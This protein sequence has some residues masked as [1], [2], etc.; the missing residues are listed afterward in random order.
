MSR[1]SDANEVA[2]WLHYA[3]L[4]SPVDR[5]ELLEKSQRVAKRATNPD[6]S[7]NPRYSWVRVASEILRA[8]PRAHVYFADSRN[9]RLIRVFPR[10]EDTPIGE[11]IA[12][13]GK[14]NQWHEYA[15]KWFNREVEIAEYYV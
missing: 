4:Y 15:S 7:S 11:F 8:F 10:N 2:E 3:T 14:I 6:Y 1:T 13:G 12:C 9:L 5:Q